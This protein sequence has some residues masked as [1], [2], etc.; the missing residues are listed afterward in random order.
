MPVTGR[1]ADGA[2]GG[3]G[4]LVVATMSSLAVYDHVLFWPAGVQ[5]VL[6]DLVAPLGLAPG[7]GRP[8]WSGRVA[9]LVEAPTEAV[10]SAYL[11]VGNAVGIGDR[12]GV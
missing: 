3:L 11:Q 2:C 12:L 7:E 4:V 10:A 8:N 6:L 1:N 9:V 5:N